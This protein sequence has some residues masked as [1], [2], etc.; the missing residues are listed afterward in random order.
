MSCIQIIDFLTTSPQNYIFN[1]KKNKSICGGILFLLIIIATIF[2]AVDHTLNFIYN[3]KYDIESYK[4]QKIPFKEERDRLNNNSHYNPNIKFKLGLY[5]FNSQNLSK[6][7]I[8]YDY[9]NKILLERDKVYNRTISDTTFYILYLCKDKQCLIDNNDTQKFFYKFRLLFEGCNVDHENKSNPIQKQD[10]QMDVPFYFNTPF[11]STLKWQV[12][13]YSDRRTFSQLWNKFKGLDKEYIWGFFN[14]Y[15]TFLMESK[16]LI[17]YNPILGYYKVLSI[18][19]LA[20]QH[21]ETLEYKRK[22][23]NILDVIS[24]VGSLFL[25]ILSSI[26]FIFSF[27]TESFKNSEIMKKIFLKEPKKINNLKGDEKKKVEEKKIE[28]PKNINVSSMD[29]ID[30][31]NNEN[32]LFNE[33]SPKLCCLSYILNSAYCDCCKRKCGIN[34]Q[35]FIKKCNEIISKYLSVDYILYNQIK[36]ENLFNDYIWNNKKLAEI[37]NNDS[38]KNFK[39]DFIL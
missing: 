35:N 5:H 29:I 39:N 11:I 36:L 13:K 10:T 24:N 26:R 16:D 14:S 31:D 33:N 23:K 37:D 30:N 2:Y 25:T 7:F 32:L 34:S 3:E 21:E 27:H 8:L 4:I 15:T 28:L 1:E 22:F 17:S 12:V 6:N 18:I 20:N 19:I 38:I 9:N